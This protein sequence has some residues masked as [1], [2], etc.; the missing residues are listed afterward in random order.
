MRAFDR[1]AGYLKSS[2]E[3]AD[4]KL[5]VDEQTKARLAQAK[6][7]TGVAVGVTATVVD[8]VTAAAAS[9]GSTIAAAFNDTGYGERL[10]QATNTETGVA[11]RQVALS[12]IAAA[13]D[14][15]MSATDL[16]WSATF[17][18]SLTS[19]PTSPR[20]PAEHFPLGTSQ[21]GPG[22]NLRV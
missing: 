20:S 13:G 14:A 4:A 8:A 12:G 9:F 19:V 21:R 18:H 7:V 15:S 10:A 5:S 22:L 2:W 11:V 6:A 1:T 3:P 17:S 16:F